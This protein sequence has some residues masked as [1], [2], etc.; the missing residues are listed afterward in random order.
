MKLGE[1]IPESRHD[2]ARSCRDKIPYPSE[3][4]ANAAAKRQAATFSAEIEAYD[5]LHCDGWHTGNVPV[6][7]RLDREYDVW[8]A[9]G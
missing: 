7:L 8:S 9:V 2:P 3:D 5:C 1:P 4:G 6:W